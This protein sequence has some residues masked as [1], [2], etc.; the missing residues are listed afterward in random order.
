MKAEE[1]RHEVDAM[2]AVGRTLQAVQAAEPL[3]T[4]LLAAIGYD[5]LGDDAG[6]DPG[7]A[8]VAPAQSA[9]DRTAAV[10]RFEAQAREVELSG[11][12]LRQ[13]LSAYSA[14]RLADLTPAQLAEAAAAIGTGDEAAAFNGDGFARAAA[15]R[16]RRAP[17]RQRQ[18]AHAKAVVAAGERFGGE[19]LAR[20]KVALDK[21]AG[22]PV[23][24]DA[25]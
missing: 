22:L 10:E 12:G 8:P 14:T 23:D 1:A 11:D 6:S 21:A 19:L 25:R 4:G 7:P 9:D 20:V 13:L 16:I 15:D 3:A 2:L 24:P 5:V 17:E 18:K